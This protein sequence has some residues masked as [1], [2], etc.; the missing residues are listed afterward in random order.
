MSTSRTSA[1]AIAARYATA[2]FALAT[3]AKKEDAVVAEITAVA[4]AITQNSELAAALNNPL[5]ARDKK[6]DLLRAVAKGAQKL[7]LD[8]LGV[9]AAEGRATVLPQIAKLLR[10]RLA[11]ARGELVA[12]VESARPLPASVQKDL[13]ASL[14]KATGKTV[15]LNIIEN[16]ALLGGVAIQIGSKRLDASLSAALTTIRREL[17]ASSN[18]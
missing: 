6:S 10:A 7:T 17:L 13:A 11:D 18:A 4:D 14:S 1:T 16:P 8:S 15:K 5:T 12:D 3:E 2:I 9:I